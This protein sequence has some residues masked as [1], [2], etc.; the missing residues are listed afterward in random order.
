VAELEEKRPLYFEKG[1]KEF[2]LCDDGGNIRFFDPERE[3]ERSEL[4][5]EFPGRIDIGVE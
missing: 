1:A 2:W 4:F 5:P 3:L